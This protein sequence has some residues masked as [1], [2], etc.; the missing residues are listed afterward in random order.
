[1]QKLYHPQGSHREDNAMTISIS[2]PFDLV[3]MDF[4]SAPSGY[5]YT[6][7]F[8]DHFTKFAVVVP[9]KDQTATTT[10]KLF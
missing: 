2:E 4:S 5:Q 6:L 10:A 1:M 3:T 7:V 8:V 9:T